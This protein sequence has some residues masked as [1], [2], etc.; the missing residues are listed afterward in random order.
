MKFFTY[1][2]TVGRVVLN[3]DEIL[4]VKALEAL[5][6]TQRNKT[7]EDK[8]GIKKERAFKELTYIFLFFDWESPYFQYVEKD[9]HLE[10]LKDSGMTSEEFNDPLFKEACRKYDEI[11]NASKI[12]RLLKAS[13]LT[14]DKIT[15]Y[16]ENID[17]NERDDA[18]GKP[19]FKTK[20]VIAEINSA[21]KL[22]D[23]VKAL[24]ISFKKE[25]E[26]E[27]ALRGDISTGLYD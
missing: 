14:I 25:I 13:Y 26:P 24:E 16:L 19:I 2:R 23:S 21:S 12:G 17:L 20:D 1:D 7:L 9:R 4:L 10:S 15:H 27:N 5:L 18:T 6:D 22:Y 11:Q 3:K 8:K